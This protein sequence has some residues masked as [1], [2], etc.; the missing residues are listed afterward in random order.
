MSYDFSGKRRSVSFNMA[1]MDALWSAATR[2]GWKP[3]GTVLKPWDAEQAKEMDQA[4]RA[5]AAKTWEGHYHFN[6]WQTVTAPDA[7]AWADALEKYL[8]AE[9]VE[10]RWEKKIRMFVAMCRDGEFRIG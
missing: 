10:E 5:E 9:T 7:A 4:R 2:Y 3:A 1:G 6:D 8:A